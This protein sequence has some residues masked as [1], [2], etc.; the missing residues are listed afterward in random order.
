MERLLDAINGIC[1]EYLDY[2]KVMFPVEKRDAL[3]RDRVLDDILNNTDTADRLGGQLS[4]M[5]KMQYG[6]EKT[7]RLMRNLWKQ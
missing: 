3:L 5:Q 6:M 2:P 7:R 4:F 1:V